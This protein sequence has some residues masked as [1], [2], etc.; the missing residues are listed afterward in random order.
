[1][2]N[3]R[4]SDCLMFFSLS[5]FINFNPHLFSID[6]HFN[7]A[8]CRC[9]LWFRWWRRWRMFKADCSRLTLMFIMAVQIVNVSLE[10]L[11]S[12]IGL[13]QVV[14]EVCG[15]LLLEEVHLG[16]KWHSKTNFWAIKCLEIVDGNYG[17]FKRVYYVSYQ[18]LNYLSIEARS[19]NGKLSQRAH[20][21]SHNVATI[22]VSIPIISLAKTE[23]RRS[24]VWY[25]YSI[26][27]SHLFKNISPQN[28]F[29]PPTTSCIQWWTLVLLKTRH[30]FLDIYARSVHFQIYYRPLNNV[31]D[32]GISWVLQCYWRDRWGLDGPSSEVQGRVD[33][34]GLSVHTV[35]ERGNFSER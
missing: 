7:H 11:V 32:V 33:S 27:E 16:W 24:E 6:S 18:F 26:F 15:K 17:N 29:K 34:M 35:Q 14:D 19:N 10:P 23:H 28:T 12:D 30:S 5:S 3:V 1:M 21:S 4:A 25:W 8:L 22:Q 20:P 13:W 9:W 31:D 2:Y